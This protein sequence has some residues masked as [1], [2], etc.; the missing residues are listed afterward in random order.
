MN[1]T[2]FWF[3]VLVME[4]IHLNVPIIKVPRSRV[5]GAIWDSVSSH[6]CIF[7]HIIHEHSEIT[8]KVADHQINSASILSF[9]S[10]STFWLVDYCAVL[11][12][13]KLASVRYGFRIFSHALLLWEKLKLLWK[14]NFKNK[15]CAI[16]TRFFS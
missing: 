7:Q 2:L 11:G 6:V 13:W 8:E 4:E 5:K 1:M 15:T 9:W 16:S 12:P 10:K 14:K 3:A